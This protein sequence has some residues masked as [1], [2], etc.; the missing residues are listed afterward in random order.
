MSCIEKDRGRSIAAR[1]AA[2]IHRSGNSE[3]FVNS[4]PPGGGGARRGTRKKGGAFEE[5]VKGG[6]YYSYSIMFFLKKT[7]KT[8]HTDGKKNF[9]FKNCYVYI[10]RYIYFEEVPKSKKMCVFFHH[11]II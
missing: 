11:S 10:Y 7:K 5:V 8:E 6:G 9:Y 1:R 3:P 2:P 4:P